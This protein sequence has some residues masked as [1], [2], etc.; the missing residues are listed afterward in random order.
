MYIFT[1]EN[2]FH[3]RGG[4]VKVAL[5]QLAREAEVISLAPMVMEPLGDIEFPVSFQLAQ[6]A[7]FSFQ[8]IVALQLLLRVEAGLL[9]S[10]C[11]GVEACCQPH[12]DPLCV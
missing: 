12:V 5:L 10:A 3:F 4:L 8:G 9:N 11:L 6:A 7:Q 1:H 2:T